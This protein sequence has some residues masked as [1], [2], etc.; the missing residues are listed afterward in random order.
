MKQAGLNARVH[1][2]ACWDGKNLDP[3]DHTSHVAFLSDLD[4]GDC[5]S[6]HPIGFI[7]MFYEVQAFLSLFYRIKLTSSYR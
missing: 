3:P 5:P 2:P 6:T 4:N 7:K 1:M